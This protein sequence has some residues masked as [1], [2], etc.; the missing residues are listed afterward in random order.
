MN[1]DM[2]H[3][4]RVCGLINQPQ[5]AITFSH[6]VYLTWSCINAIFSMG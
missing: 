5:R 3:T 4:T 1:I 2:L 6:T